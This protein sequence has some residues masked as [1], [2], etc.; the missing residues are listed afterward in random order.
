[1]LVR[2]AACGVCR[3]DLHVVE[4]DLAVHRPGVIPGHEIVGLVEERGAGAGRFPPGARVGI[5]LQEVSEHPASTWDFTLTP[6]ERSLLDSRLA[7]GDDDPA[8]A[9]TRFF[10]AKEAVA[11]AEV[12][13]LR[14]NPRHF[15]VT[16]INTETTVPTVLT[17]QVD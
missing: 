14:G 11:K 1:M 17:V 15:V 2:V 12:T 4:G 10:T 13:G 6:A 3:T 8:T 16:T 9:F 7:A 5:D